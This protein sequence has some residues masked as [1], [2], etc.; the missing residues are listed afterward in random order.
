MLQAKKIDDFDY[1]IRRE[2]KLKHS[3]TEGK[4]I[5]INGIY[6]S[7]ENDPFVKGKIRITFEGSQDLCCVEDRDLVEIR[8]ITEWDKQ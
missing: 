7:L 6:L 8:K 5:K 1:L 2:R 4:R 3:V